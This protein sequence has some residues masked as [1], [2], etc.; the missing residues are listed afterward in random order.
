M[1]KKS[2][3]ETVNWTAEGIQAF[4]K[5]KEILVSFPVMANPDFSRPFILQTDASSRSSAQSS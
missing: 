4:N 3:P 5:L 2:E 1:I